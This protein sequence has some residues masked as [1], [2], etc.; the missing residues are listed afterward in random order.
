MQPSAHC[1]AG[2]SSATSD[3]CFLSLPSERSPL[4]R[5]LLF[6][7]DP[8]AAGGCSDLAALGGKLTPPA[9]LEIAQLGPTRPAQGMQGKCRVP[10]RHGVNQTPLLAAD[11]ADQQMYSRFG[12]PGPTQ[13]PQAFAAN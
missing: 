6:F 1:S 3:L 11:H 13:T 8:M 2:A 12:A 10:A 4:S 7:S 9:T 5:F